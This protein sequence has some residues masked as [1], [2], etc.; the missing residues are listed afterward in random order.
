AEE[1]HKGQIEIMRGS[2]AD[3]LSDRLTALLNFQLGRGVTQRQ[4]MSV[5]FAYYGE[6]GARP[7][8]QKI[9][10]AWD[11]AAARELEFLFASVIREGGYTDIDPGELAIGYAALIDGLH[12]ALLVT[13]R[14]LTKQS[15]KKI[16]RDFLQRA[17][18]NHI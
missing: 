14:E 2:E 15:A 7:V 11:R 18:P 10:S 3:N 1:Y 6:V 17:F 9:V 13:P 4:K 8:Y 5:W 12:L 16:G